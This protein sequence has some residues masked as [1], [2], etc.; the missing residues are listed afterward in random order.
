MNF[1]DEMRSDYN[2]TGI[3]LNYYDKNDYY[4]TSVPYVDKKTI[5]YDMLMENTEK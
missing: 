3:Y 2:F 5:T 1:I 4:K